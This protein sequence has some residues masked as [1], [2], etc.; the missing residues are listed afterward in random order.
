MSLLNEFTD[1][2]NKIAAIN[3]DILNRLLGKQPF[4]ELMLQ[5][6]QRGVIDFKEDKWKKLDTKSRAELRIFVFSQEI[7]KK[8][9]P[10]LFPNVDFNK[11][12][13][14]IPQ[15]FPNPS[16]LSPN[17]LFETINSFE[18]LVDN[19]LIDTL[20]E[21]TYIDC[22]IDFIKV[23]ANYLLSLLTPSK[24]QSFFET[25]SL[26]L[27]QIKSQQ[28]RLHSI[29]D[30]L[31]EIERTTA[32]IPVPEGFKVPEDDDYSTKNMLGIFI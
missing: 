13:L 6:Q 3:M 23:C 22:A 15:N 30:K 10:R 29:F 21:R 1:S 16:C 28:Q 25:T 11:F 14:I 19:Y 32:L 4:R 18:K 31:S 2:Y 8:I 5:M 20:A 7:A 17:E 26:K 12:Q 27:E 24:S 9:A